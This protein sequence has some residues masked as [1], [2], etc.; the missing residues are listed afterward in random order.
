MVIS[1]HAFRT[2]SAE[3]SLLAREVS[4]LFAVSPAE[5][6]QEGKKGREL[7]MDDFDVACSERPY[8]DGWF[9]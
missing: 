7:G 1:G 6:S 4:L 2:N 9:G 8:I 3:A 5:A